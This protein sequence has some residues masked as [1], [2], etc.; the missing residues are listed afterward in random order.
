[1]SPHPEEQDRT[2]A[3][4]VARVLTSRSKSR[5]LH[6]ADRH[7][8]RAPSLVGLAVLGGL[9]VG[10]G[11]MLARELLRPRPARTPAPPPQSSR[12]RIA[13]RAGVWA[14]PYVLRLMARAR[15]R[16]ARSGEVLK[17]AAPGPSH[18]TN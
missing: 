12:W 2:R 3:A 5:L 10:G 14:F 4:R 13:V 7:D 15:E 11:G 16:Q 17:H 1:M 8:A 9:A 18:R 6:W